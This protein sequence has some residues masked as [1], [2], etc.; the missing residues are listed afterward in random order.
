M[1]LHRFSAQTLGFDEVSEHF[2]QLFPHTFESQRIQQEACFWILSYSSL[3]YHQNNLL[4]VVSSS[5][6]LP[7][8]IVPRLT[9]SS[10][11]QA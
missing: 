5:S 6:H 4:I 1:V 9:W 3:S 2:S 11:E 8:V 10:L 7:I